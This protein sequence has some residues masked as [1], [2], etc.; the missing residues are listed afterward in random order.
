[1]FTLRFNFSPKIPLCVFVHLEKPGSC[2]MNAI[3]CFQK[4]FNLCS[5]DGGCPGKEKC[6]GYRCGK[7]CL[8][9]IR[10]YA[11]YVVCLM[12]SCSDRDGIHF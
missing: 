11:N 3:R 9:N 6:C 5:G 12:F 1:T 2:P 7:T 8:S 4:S 10:R